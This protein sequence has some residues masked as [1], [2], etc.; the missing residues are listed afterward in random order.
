MAGKAEQVDAHS[1]PMR[2]PTSRKARARDHPA[3]IL[4]GQPHAATQSKLGSP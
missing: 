1:S 3:I 2:K 4:G